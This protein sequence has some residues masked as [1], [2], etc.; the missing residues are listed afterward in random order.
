MTKDERQLIRMM[1]R[2]FKDKKKN[3]RNIEIKDLP[4]E[5]DSSTLETE[6]SKAI[7]EDP[8]II[9]KSDFNF[10]F[11]LD[12]DLSFDEEVDDSIESEPCEYKLKLNDGNEI[13][14]LPEK[15]LHN[16]IKDCVEEIIKRNQNEES[17]DLCESEE[18]NHLDTGLELDDDTLDD[19]LSTKPKRLYQR[20]ILSDPWLPFENDCRL[21]KFVVYDGNS[22]DLEF[23]ILLNKSPYLKNE[24]TDLNDPLN[25]LR[26][27]RNLVEK[28]SSSENNIKCNIIYSYN[29]NSVNL[30]DVKYAISGRIISMEILQTYGLELRITVKGKIINHA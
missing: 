24:L 16:I 23:S 12:D 13:I 1:N 6:S 7:E 8:I 15:V 19:I 18:N 30:N 10:S 25:V 21:D 9:P 26:R 29:N 4:K 28:S 2:S 14:S 22:V 3:S 27:F 20:F 17:N 5:T 11:D